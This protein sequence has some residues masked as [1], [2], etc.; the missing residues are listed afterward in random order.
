MMRCPALYRLALAA[1]LVLLAL[2][3]VADARP[4]TREILDDADD[5]GGDYNLGMGSEFI[6]LTVSRLP[7]VYLHKPT[8]WVCMCLD[9]L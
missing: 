9:I 5:A 2:S 7:W 1:A 6:S 8:V 3:L 4:S